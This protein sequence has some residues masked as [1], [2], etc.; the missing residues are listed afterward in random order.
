VLL[1]PEISDAELAGDAAAVMLALGDAPNI[2]SACQK[3]V[4]IKERIDGAKEA[5]VS[6][7]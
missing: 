5:V 3:I 2:S 1:I 6:P 4:V 7:K